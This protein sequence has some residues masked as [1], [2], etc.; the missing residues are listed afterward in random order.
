[1]HGA[2][3]AEIRGSEKTRRGAKSLSHTWAVILSAAKSS[4]QAGIASMRSKTI[5]R[6][7]SWILRCAQ[8][9]KPLYH[10]GIKKP[11]R[12][13]SAWFQRRVQP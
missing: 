8:D 5:S 4:Q 7:R 13:E 12:D 9:D 6:S 1:M 11:T 2:T 3:K 10:A